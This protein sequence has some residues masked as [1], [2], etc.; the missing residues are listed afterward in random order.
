[1]VM[2]LKIVDSSC[3]LQLVGYSETKMR[4]VEELSFLTAWLPTEKICCRE[5][6]KLV[7][8]TMSA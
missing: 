7:W 6:E 8:G 3:G 4:A 1:M 2:L 5:I